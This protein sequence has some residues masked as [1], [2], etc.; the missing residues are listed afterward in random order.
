[1][2]NLLFFFFCLPFAL[3]AQPH[4]EYEQNKFPTQELL[5]NTLSARLGTQLFFSA[6]TGYFGCK[7]HQLETATGKIKVVKGQSAD[8]IDFVAKNYATGK[9]QFIAALAAHSDIKGALSDNWDRLVL[10][11][12]AND[13][14]QV[15]LNA[16][17]MTDLV[18][19][20]LLSTKIIKNRVFF[21]ANPIVLGQV[22]T[23]KQVY[24]LDVTTGK[25]IELKHPVTGEAVKIRTEIHIAESEEFAYFMTDFTPNTNSNWYYD[26]LKWTPGNPLQFCG[27]MQGEPIE[28]W[29]LNDKNLYIRTEQVGITHYY[30]VGHQTLNLSKVTAWEGLDLYIQDDFVLQFKNN[31]MSKI[32]LNTSVS[33]T[34]ATGQSYGSGTLKKLIPLHDELVLV[35]NGKWHRLSL[36]DFSIRTDSVLQKAS[37]WYPYADLAKIKQD[38]YIFAY[39][40]L[41]KY[42][43]SATVA[44]PI[45]IPSTTNSSSFIWE[46]LEKGDKV[47]IRYEDEIVMGDSKGFDQPIILTRSNLDLAPYAIEFQDMPGSD[48]MIFRYPDYGVN[49]FNPKTLEM[50]NILASEDF[51]HRGYVYAFGDLFFHEPS[52][53]IKRFHIASESYSSDSIFSNSGQTLIKTDNTDFLFTNTNTA[54]KISDAT[55]VVFTLD[56]YSVGAT[57]KSFVVLEPDWQSPNK[58]IL[59]YNLITGQL[60]TVPNTVLKTS[61]IEAAEHESTLYM[62]AYYAN[63]IVAF[64][65]KNKTSEVI[66]YTRPAYG[67]LK[68]FDQKLYFSTQTL[69]QGYNLIEYDPATKT[70]RLATQLRY[71]ATQADIDIVYP[72]SKKLYFTANDGIHG[73]EL[74]SLNN[75]FS[76][77]LVIENAQGNLPNGSISAAILG[78]STPF[79]YQWSTGSTEETIK[80]LKA[81]VYSLTLTDATGCK[82]S[83]SG[84]VGKGPLIL[85]SEI[86]GIAVIAYPNPLSDKLSLVAPDNTVGQLDVTFYQASG[87]LQMETQWETADPLEL[88]IKD[89]RSG[90]YYCKLKGKNGETGIMSILKL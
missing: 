65:T 2:K 56:N 8:S 10:Y 7:L 48:W 4:L 22:A 24:V 49:L 30:Q 72:G 13:S 40:S 54:V 21:S 16:N 11:D 82:G 23:R 20:R 58:P 83:F 69:S 88:D 35:L 1:L 43:P 47:L 86:G 70:T 44:Q 3:F 71:R 28:K 36:S 67:T 50:K 14:L 26:V 64:D 60:D 62:V 27:S 5:P 55:H 12:L 90:T 80:N 68:V 57:T 53:E 18:Y 15:L 38:I 33:K 25:Y 46:V 81:G 9:N 45:T 75:C 63:E 6:N 37:K 31:A 32:D 17:T 85:Q 19:M 79:Q 89:W 39:T 52:G 74:W 87:H 77:E 78:G 41:H 84:Y 66:S 34:I 59:I 42:S 61:I 29:Y 51:I 73:Y 76:A